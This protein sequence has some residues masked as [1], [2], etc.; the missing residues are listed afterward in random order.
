M[1]QMRTDKNRNPPPKK[2]RELWKI[3]EDTDELY[4][5]SNR[6]RVRRLRHVKHAKPP[7]VKSV[8]ET[9]ASTTEFARRFGVTPTAIHYVAIGRNHA[10]V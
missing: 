3:I 9:K 10:T 2:S 1:S 8:P 6:G 5:V 7:G 4:E